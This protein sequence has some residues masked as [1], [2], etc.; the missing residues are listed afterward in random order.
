[1]LT[2]VWRNGSKWFSPLS[3]GKL[4]AWLVLGL[5]PELLLTPTSFK[6]FWRPLT[7]CQPLPI[8]RW[9]QCW[10]PQHVEGPV[11]KAAPANGLLTRHSSLHL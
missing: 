8:C 6:H 1:M 9:R 5:L 10:L 4:S 3:L 2:V 7:T 11:S